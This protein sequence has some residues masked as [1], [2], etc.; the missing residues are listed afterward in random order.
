MF[1]VVLFWLEMMCK[2][3]TT[4]SSSDVKIDRW[5]KWKNFDIFYDFT[6]FT[7]TCL[8]E[9]PHSPI[10]WWTMS[11]QEKNHYSQDSSSSHYANGIELNENR[12]IFISVHVNSRSLSADIH[13]SL[14]TGENRR[15]EY[16][17]IFSRMCCSSFFS[18]SSSPSL[19]CYV[20]QIL[21]YIPS[22]RRKI[23]LSWREEEEKNFFFR[24]ET[25]DSSTCI[26]TS[27]IIRCVCCTSSSINVRKES[28][29]GSSNHRDKKVPCV[30]VCPNLELAQIIDFTPSC[31]R[32][33]SGD[34]VLFSPSLCSYLTVLPKRTSAI[35]ASRCA[36]RKIQG[37]HGK[38][39]VRTLTEF[40]FNRK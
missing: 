29:D 7:I 14:I 21:V 30:C 20:L 26:H 18:S 10:A 27:P 31:L 13:S 3:W 8:K 34:E 23:L 35:I 39:H 5:C 12:S 17:F 1:L 28:N 22:S 37:Y 11:D 15:Q 6:F 38:M 24:R 32:D 16:Y 36:L 25:F 33:I 9:I 4:S 40:G 19:V 2:H